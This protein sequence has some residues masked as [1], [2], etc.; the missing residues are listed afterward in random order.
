MGK[1]VKDPAKDAKSEWGKTGQAMVGSLLAT[2]KAAAQAAGIIKTI[3]L[4]RAVESAQKLQDVT[5]RI[6]QQ[7][8]LRQNEVRSAERYVGK[9]WLVTPER[10]GEAVGP[11]AQQIGDPKAAFRAYSELA[12]Y[13]LAQGLTPE[14]AQPAV[15][16]LANGLHMKEG[17]GHF[18]ELTRDIGTNLQLGPNQILRTLQGLRGELQKVKV[19]SDEARVRLAAM[20]GVLGG[21][22]RTPDDQIR[23]A[24]TLIGWVQSNAA[25]IE[26][27]TKK[28]ISDRNTGKVDVVAGAQAA[29]EFA[30]KKFKGRPA[31]MKDHALFWN[32]DP[33][34][35]A[36]LAGDELGQIDRVAAE[37]RDRGE[38][39]RAAGYYRRSAEGQ[40]REE[41]LHISDWET[42][43][44][45]VFLRGGEKITESLGPK[46]GAAA[47]LVG[48]LA[49]DVAPHL[50]G[51]AK[52]ALGGAA[53]LFG[54]GAV[55]AGA[56]TE[57]RDDGNWTERAEDTAADLRARAAAMQAAARDPDGGFR[58]AAAAGNRPAGRR[59]N[60]ALSGPALAGI[61]RAV[62]R[63]TRKGNEQAAKRRPKP[64]P[65]PNA[66]RGNR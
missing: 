37:A 24:S 56:A 44:G 41:D 50:T 8:G 13:G 22:D 32:L 39:A 21:K 34:L 42:A 5:T 4:S 28:T 14:Q 25:N 10:I 12:D 36:V 66:D 1:A 17:F 43:G 16:T 35:A 40:K 33:E 63:G 9:Q 6:A 26:R 45:E 53:L 31:A 27:S 20:V 55:V 49:A 48:G 64:R 59:N 61:E 62:E 11:L 52:K 30:Q 38:W 3:D 15:E 7:G 65:D 29:W 18:A 19:D 57:P 58:R 46:A 60:G 2:A 47:K 54:T 23:V 51:S